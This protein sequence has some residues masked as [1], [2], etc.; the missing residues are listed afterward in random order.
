[1]QAARPSAILDLIRSAEHFAVALGAQPQGSSAAAAGAGGQLAAKGDQSQQG[2]D[3]LTTTSV[4]MQ[5]LMLGGGKASQAV[6]GA[7][8]CAGGTCSNQQQDGCTR[9]GRGA[10]GLPQ[11]L[12]TEQQNLADVAGVDGAHEASP[13]GCLQGTGTAAACTGVPGTCKRHATGPAAG[14][15]GRTGAAPAVQDPGPTQPPAGPGPP[16]NSSTADAAPAVPSSSS[17]QGTSL[18]QPPV[19]SADAPPGS[20][21]ALSGG[22]M[23][24][25]SFT[26]GGPRQCQR[27]GYLT[28]QPV[29]KACVL[30]ETLN[31]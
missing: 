17:K 1:M 6:A 29:C 21:A 16:H 24:R 15:S 23:P 26:Q 18:G 9:H 4:L 30:L 31:K 2:S 5:Q 20:A 3:G 25:A 10:G 14:V 19:P 12:P 13:N 7:G 11:G 8:Q 27:C 28:S 22:S